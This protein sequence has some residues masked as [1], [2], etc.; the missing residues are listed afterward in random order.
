[1]MKR[2][3]HTE[4]IRGDQHLHGSTESLERLSRE[5][6]FFVPDTLALL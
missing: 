3:V 4:C 2:A 5:L 1:M 6:A